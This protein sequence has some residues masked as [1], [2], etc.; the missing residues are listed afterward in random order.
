MCEERVAGEAVAGAD[1]EGT[2]CGLFA[3]RRGQTITAAA[4]AI[5]RA[6]EIR[7]RFI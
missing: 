6:M 3:E 2:V 7:W 5:K 1:A 4:A